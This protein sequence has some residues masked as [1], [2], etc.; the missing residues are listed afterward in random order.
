MAVA[1][2][3]GQSSTTAVDG[4]CHFRHR[5]RSAGEAELFVIA[6]PGTALYQTITV[7]AAS[8]LE[9]GELHAPHAATLHVKV[10]APA[11]QK[12]SGHS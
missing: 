9:L 4:T 10:K 7:E 6:T 11:K 1:A 2:I 3:V 5:R 12:V 8:V